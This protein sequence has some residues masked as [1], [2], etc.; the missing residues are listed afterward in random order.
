[1]LQKYGNNLEIPN[2]FAIF[3]EKFTKFCVFEQTEV[4]ALALC[5]SKNLRTQKLK[6][7]R[8]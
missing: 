6:N 8:T 4:T 2:V 5:L 7:L 3:A 1:M